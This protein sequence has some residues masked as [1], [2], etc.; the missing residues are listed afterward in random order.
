MKTSV[1]EDY[2][3]TVEVLVGPVL[4]DG[5]RGRELPR[6]DEAEALRR[7]RR[8]MGVGEVDDVSIDPAG[9]ELPVGVLAPFRFWE[10][11]LAKGVRIVFWYSSATTPATSL[12]P[13]NHGRCFST[14][15]GVTGIGPF[16]SRS[17][18]SRTE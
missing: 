18:H 8:E 1:S 13:R 6:Y 7:L 12:P 11:A 15:A 9:V 4:D 14:L 5:R 17:V 3:G 16:S 10:K 2:E